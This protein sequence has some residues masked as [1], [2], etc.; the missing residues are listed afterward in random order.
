M[1]F[2]AVFR[3]HLSSYHLSDTR[4]FF[5]DFTA[6]VKY[7]GE[8][9]G[10]LDDPL[11]ELGLQ[12][13]ILK[14]IACIYWKGSTD[15]I[16]FFLLRWTKMFSH[17]TLCVP[18]RLFSPSHLVFSFFLLSLMLLFSISPTLFLSLSHLLLSVLLSFL[19]PSP[20]CSSCSLPPFLWI[21]SSLV[22][23]RHSDRSSSVNK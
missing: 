12:Q 15:L 23:W 16:L 7:D 21:V 1:V 17:S 5:F 14:Y 22:V 20:L 18:S 10:K 3:S 9:S 13:Q 11:V 8:M 6:I 19:S 2:L 4:R